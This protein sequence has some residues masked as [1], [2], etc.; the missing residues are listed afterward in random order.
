MHTRKRAHTQPHFW[1]QAV[2]LPS[3]WL[4]DISH[5]IPLSANNSIYTLT[6]SFFF[7]SFKGVGVLF[8]SKRRPEPC[9]SKLFLRVG[10]AAVAGV[11]VCV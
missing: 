10:F 1:K 6:A 8:S 11:C 7:I 4:G 2:L 3:V 9:D 5:T